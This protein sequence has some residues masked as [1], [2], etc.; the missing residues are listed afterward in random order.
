MDF[1]KVRSDFAYG[2]NRNQ[3][4]KKQADLLTEMGLELFDDRHVICNAEQAMRLIMQG[5]CGEYF[6]IDTLEA[7]KIPVPDLLSAEVV[8]LVE[9]SL[10]KLTNKVTDLFNQKTGVEQPSIALTD[11]TETMLLQ[12][13]CTDAL[14][15]NIRE[16]WRILAICPQP[17]RRPDY[18]LGRIYLPGFAGRG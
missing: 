10:D 5:F 2:E 8:C 1:Y 11:V 16:G 6:S 3:V 4:L 15:E 12:D 7:V 9:K 17:Q 18:V 13:A 14:Q